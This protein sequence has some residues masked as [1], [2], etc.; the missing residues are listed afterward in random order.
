MKYPVYHKQTK[1]VDLKYFFI[2]E[3]WEKKEV[4][5]VYINTIALLADYLQSLYLETGFNCSVKLWAWLH[6][7]LN[8]WE[9]ICLI[10]VMLN[11]QE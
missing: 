2:R 3:L 10:Y 4:D 8:E 11:I 1:H 5:Y 7:P 9:F 6:S